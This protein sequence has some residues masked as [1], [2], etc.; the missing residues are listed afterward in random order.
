MGEG[1]W[2]RNHGG[3]VMEEKPWLQSHGD[4]PWRR[5]HGGEILEESPWTEIMEE[6]SWLRR[7]GGEIMDETSWMASGSRGTQEAPRRPPGSIS[8]IFRRHPGGSEQ[9]SRRPPEA[10][11]LGG[12][13]KPAATL[14]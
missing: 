4:N 12:A 10:P 6:E 7:R 9:A 14:R 5:N 8:E 13:E 2:S 1:S 11:H 3:G